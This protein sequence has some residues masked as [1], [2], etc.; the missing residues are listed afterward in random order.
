MKPRTVLVLVGLLSL[1]LPTCPCHTRL[2]F[3]AD[4]AVDMGA[5]LRWEDLQ[6]LDYE[7]GVVPPE[8]RKLEGKLV[9]VA[10]FAVPLGDDGS[11]KLAEFVLVPQPMMCIHV[12]PPPPNQIL[13][14]KMK[15]AVLIESLY[16][17]VW[18]TGTLKIVNPK[19]EYGDASFE[20]AGLRVTPYEGK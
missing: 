17:P 16:L 2:V 8:L 4:A 11:E 10:G 15:S 1:S 7:Q 14:V 19:T 13:I 12:P 3:A 18:V 6:K 9:S 20:L 5:K